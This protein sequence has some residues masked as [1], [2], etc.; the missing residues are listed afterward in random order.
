MEKMKGFS[1][2]DFRR[3]L[4]KE[5]EM[6]SRVWPHIT[7]MPEAFLDAK[8]QKRYNALKEL[9]LILEYGGVPLFEQYR[10]QAI[11]NAEAVETAQRDLFGE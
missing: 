6:R 9:L 1:V 8:H 10:R 5:L 7:G 3:E 4:A 11:S 2:E